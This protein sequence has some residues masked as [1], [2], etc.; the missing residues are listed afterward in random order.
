MAVPFAVGQLNVVVQHTEPSDARGEC[1]EH[2]RAG[3]E[4]VRLHDV[5]TGADIDKSC[6]GHAR[7][8]CCGSQCV[9]AISPQP[10][11]VLQSATPRFRCEP[12]PTLKIDEGMLARRYRP[13]IA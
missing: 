3:I 12:E 9:S 10:V 8:S 2:H 13:P 4:P 5:A 11:S 6:V 7:S 1:P